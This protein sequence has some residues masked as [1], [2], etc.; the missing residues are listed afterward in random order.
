MTLSVA[1]R[2]FPLYLFGLLAVGFLVAPLLIIIPLS[3]SSAQFL[4]FPPPS[5]SNQWY[6]VILTRPQWTDAFGFSLQVALLSTAVTLV[7]GLLAAVALVRGRFRFKPLLYG[8]ILAPMIVPTIITAAALFFFFSRLHLTGN[9]EVIALGHSVLALPLAVIIISATLQGFDIRLEQ[10]AISL[11][12][13]P[14]RAFLLVTLPLI[15]PAVVSAALFAFLTSFD[16]LLISLFLAGPESTTLPVRIWN[17]VL[18][19]VEPTV[20]AVSTLLILMAV[21][22]LIA[23][24]LL[25]RLRRTGQSSNPRRM[26]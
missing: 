25:Q 13:S 2:R 17:S 10:A 5:F 7:L 15:S 4:S 16:E 21:G 8:A 6:R 3:F 24:G 11:G 9:P 1:P 23:A 20:A 12:A 19:E 26:P 22:T 14:L 18:L